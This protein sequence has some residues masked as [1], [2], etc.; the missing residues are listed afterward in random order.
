MLRV[1]RKGTPI[2]PL[3]D[4]VSS[5]IPYDGISQY[6][7]VFSGEMLGARSEIILDSCLQGFTVEG[8]GCNHYGV[9]NASVGALIINEMKLVK[10]PVRIPVHTASSPLRGRPSTHPSC[11]PSERALMRLLAC[12]R[13][14][15]L[16]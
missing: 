7:A 8:T 12:V 15:M 3:E 4:A 13:D 11:S 14:F 6:D 9:T 1:C 10:G 5:T 16:A 2:E